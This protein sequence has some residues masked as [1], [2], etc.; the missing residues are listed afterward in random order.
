MI[1]IAVGVIDTFSH[2]G[3]CLFTLLLESLDEQ[4]FLM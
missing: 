3:A 2:C 1:W 4:K